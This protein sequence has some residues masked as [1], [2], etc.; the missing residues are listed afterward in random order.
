MCKIFT[1]SCLTGLTPRNQLGSFHIK[2]DDAVTEFGANSF[3]F[4]SIYFSRILNVCNA[5]FE[6]KGVISSLTVCMFTSRS[7]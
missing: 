2:N 3:K 7:L 5:S 4:A 6:N 1:S